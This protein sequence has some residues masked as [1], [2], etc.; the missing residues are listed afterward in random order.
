MLLLRASLIFAL[1]LSVNT[2]MASESL[3]NTLTLYYQGEQPLFIAKKKDSRQRG[4]CGTSPNTW[5]LNLC[6]SN[7]FCYLTEEEV[8]L[9]LPEAQRLNQR[10]RVEIKN[11]QNGAKTQLIWPALTPTLAWPIKKRSL[12]SG[13][14]FSIELKK[15][16]HSL[17]YKE[18]FL[19]PI[20]AYLQTNAQRAE[21]MR[22]N[23][24]TLQAERL[25]DQMT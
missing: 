23:A 13:E 18:I 10:V 22:D 8:S 14:A 6:E 12:S 9:W 15:R 4:E 21:W 19:Y 1:V 25:E 3:E 24:C 20:P 16:R 2:T 5:A 11:M 17:F 7:T